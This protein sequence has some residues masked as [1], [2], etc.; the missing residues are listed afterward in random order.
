MESRIAHL[1]GTFSTATD[2]ES[3]IPKFEVN[4]VIGDSLFQMSY[5]V[6]DEEMNKFWDTLPKE[7]GGL[8]WFFKNT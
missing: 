2:L 5:E 3:D 1:T 4:H 7:V 6:T 8:M